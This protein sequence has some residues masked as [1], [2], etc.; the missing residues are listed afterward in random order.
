MEEII[1]F[2]KNHEKTMEM[3]R[4]ADK[5]IDDIIIKEIDNS[6]FKNSEN[7][8]DFILFISSTK[9]PCC[10]IIRAITIKRKIEKMFHKNN[11]YY[12]AFTTHST[13]ENDYICYI[14]K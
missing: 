8:K 14:T 6:F 11:V 2:I 10:T 13:N 5:K 4:Y 3:L 1:E 9:E 7:V 12:S